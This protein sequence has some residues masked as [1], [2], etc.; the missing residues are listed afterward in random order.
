MP[1]KVSAAPPRWTGPA[2]DDWEVKHDHLKAPVPGERWPYGPPDAHAS[3]CNLHEN[4]LY[5]DCEISTNDP[6]G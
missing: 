2:P 6:I 1:K 4:G 3:G 5:C